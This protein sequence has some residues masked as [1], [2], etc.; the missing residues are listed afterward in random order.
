MLVEALS[1]V[2]LVL[3]GFLAISFVVWRGCSSIVFQTKHQGGTY[4]IAYSY[5]KEVR[6]GLT[7]SGAGNYLTDKVIT[8]LDSLKFLTDEI[9]NDRGIENVVVLNIMPL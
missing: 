2:V 5:S 3:F 6:G 1:C 9:A 8:D 7:V 4:L